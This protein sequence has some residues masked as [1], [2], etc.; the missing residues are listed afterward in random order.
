MGEN[1]NTFHDTRKFLNYF[2]WK[3]IDNN[4]GQTVLFWYI[5]V[6]IRHFKCYVYI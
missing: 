6:V 3:E 1:V 5:Y 2:L 4:I